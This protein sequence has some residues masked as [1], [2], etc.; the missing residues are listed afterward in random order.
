MSYYVPSYTFELL[1]NSILH[2][3]FPA[4][5]P[6]SAHGDC[7]KPTTATGN[8]FCSRGHLTP[9]GAFDTKDERDLTF[10][11]TNVAPQWQEFNAGNW[12]AVENAVKQ[13]VQSV[14][15]LV[16]VFTG[17]GKCVA[18]TY[19]PLYVLRIFLS[20]RFTILLTFA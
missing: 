18:C 10:M 14:G 12:A 6:Q 16:Y 20:I 19:V 7:S 2:D 5:N 3:S 15:H 17:T 1:I 11:M 8:Y 13:Y 9:N 4:P